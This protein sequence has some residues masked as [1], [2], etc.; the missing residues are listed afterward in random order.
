MTTRSTI[1]NYLNSQNPHINI[2]WLNDNKEIMSTTEYELKGKLE[3]DV[4][5]PPILFAEDNVVL[6][7][8]E[9]SILWRKTEKE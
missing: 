2:S 3:T 4:V 5:L 7:S 8:R 6:S 9:K 1:D